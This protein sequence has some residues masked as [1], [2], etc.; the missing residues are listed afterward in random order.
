[1]QPYAL[2]VDKF[3]EHAAKWHGAAE[4]ISAVGPTLRRK[5]Y[6]QLREWA[7]LLSGALLDQG[8]GLGDRIGTLAW[9]TED[10]LTVSY[11][12]TGAVWCATRSTRG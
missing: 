6:A 11:A 10:H 5:S 1:M 9:N 8:L 12:T 4:V 3:L 7:A 2:T